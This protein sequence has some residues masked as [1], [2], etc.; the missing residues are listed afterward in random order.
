MTCLF[1]IKVLAWAL[2][3]TT[4]TF[5]CGRCR[6]EPPEPS[7]SARTVPPLPVPLLV[8]VR[9]RQANEKG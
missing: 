3:R 7:A 9:M 6:E 1:Y 5:S 2:G 8:V 4:V